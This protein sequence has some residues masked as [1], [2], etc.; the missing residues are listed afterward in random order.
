[1]KRLIYVLAF[2]IIVFAVTKI[3][4]GISHVSSQ[5]EAMTEQ[6]G[7]ETLA[8]DSILSP[9]G[10]M[11]YYDV[12]G[13]GAPALVFV[14]C[15]SCDRSYWRNQADEFS[16][17]N[18]VVT[19]DLAGHGQ[20]GQNR[21]DWSIAAFGADI[22]AVIEKLG[23]DSVVLIG[24][25]MGGMAIVEAARQL[26]DKVIALIGIDSYN[27]IGD[28]YSDED[29]KAYLEPFRVDFKSAAYAKIAALFPENADSAL[30][31]EIAGDISSAPPDIAIPAYMATIKYIVSDPIP[32]VA[33]LKSLTVP[34]R[35]IN[36]DLFPLNDDG[37]KAAAP[38]FSV[39]VIPG[40]GHFLQLEDPE[41]F[42]RLLHETIA[43]L[44]PEP[45]S[46]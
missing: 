5:L 10:V 37:M 36:C 42:N 2:I 23:L 8:V 20:S 24:H 17:N 30:R 7:Q 14:H 22:A 41:N 12:R 27:D 26:P 38:S 35:G 1:M 13:E 3:I 33:G 4:I 15:W 19:I 21:T 29:I 18:T 11:I 34:V 31:H 6:A 45:S 16:V 43:E 44:G 9:D 46:E 40:V 32:V 39:K 25:S 28:S